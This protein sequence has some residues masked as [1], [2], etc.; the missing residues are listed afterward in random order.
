MISLRTVS[1]IVFCGEKAGK[2]WCFQFVGASA[3]ARPFI[4]RHYHERKLYDS[5]E[6]ENYRFKFVII[7]KADRQSPS[8]PIQK[9]I[10]VEIMGKVLETKGRISRIRSGYHFSF[11][12]LGLA[13]FICNIFEPILKPQARIAL[14]IQ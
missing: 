3:P 7:L 12:R 13:A 2:E 5:S 1:S 8:L 14:H 4:S 9:A 10:R 11:S 6:T